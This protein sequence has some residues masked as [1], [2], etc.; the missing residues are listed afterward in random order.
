[1]LIIINIGNN[2]INYI[3]SPMLKT[4]IMKGYII[5]FSCK[6]GEIRVGKRKW[7]LEDG[8]YVYVGSC[9]KFCYARIGRHLNEEISNRRW[10]VDYLKSLCKPILA[11][12]LPLS[13]EEI[14]S[15]LPQDLSLKDFGSSDCKIHKGHLFKL[16]FNELIEY[17]S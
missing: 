14:A 1:M 15:L 2:C 16:S 10:H 6:K 7:V 12:V 17:L 13:E 3:I 9:G 11:L 4:L 5:V 8:E